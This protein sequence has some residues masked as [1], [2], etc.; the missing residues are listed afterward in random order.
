MGFCNGFGW[1]CGM[2]WGGLGIFGPILNL[3][4]FA[5]ILAVLAL[6]T[7]WLVLQLSHRPAAYI[8]RV[9]PLEIARRRLAAGDIPLSEFEEIRGRL[10]R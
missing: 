2:T 3:V 5:G 7:I 10:Q 4:V 6:G 9:D 8:A 1:G